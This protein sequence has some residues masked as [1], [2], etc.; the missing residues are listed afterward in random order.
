MASITQTASGYRAQVYVKGVRDSAVKRTKREAAA[1][2]AA[3]ETE[4][5]EQAGKPAAVR[6]TLA[7]AMIRYRD[8]VSPEND[9]HRWEVLRINAF[10]RAD[11]GLATGLKIGEV[12]PDVLGDWRR[13]RSRKV[14]DSTILREIALLSQIFEEARRT[15]QWIAVNPVSDMRKPPQPR[16][17]EVVIDRWQIKAMLRALGYSPRRPI[18]T[19]TQAV[20]VAFLVAL[21]SGM[22][23]GELC[24]LEWTRV[25]A[26]WCVLTKTKTT[27]RDVP[28]TPKALRLI[29]RMRGFNGRLVFGVQAGSLDTLFRR[30]RKDAGLSGFTFHDSRHTA[31]TWLA[32]KLHILDLCKMFG[33][34]DTK[35]AMTYYN[36]TAADIAHRITHGQV[37]TK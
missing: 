28:L 19:V 26:S 23:A 4:I 7:E 29:G 8:E 30:A 21:R 9:G 24:G 11:S 32:Q 1:W 18:L 35:R 3:R 37:K 25:H 33:W 10:L 31:A 15:W 20:A 14:K 34:K 22:R 2:A 6:F 13:V 36:P 17:R 5:R 12:T 16:H 27:P